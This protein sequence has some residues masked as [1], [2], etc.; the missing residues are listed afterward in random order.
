MRALE[1]GAIAFGV[2][3][4]AALLFYLVIGTLVAQ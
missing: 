2:A 3:L 1:N 4:A